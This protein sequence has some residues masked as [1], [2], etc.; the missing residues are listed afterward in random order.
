[1]RET[2][3]TAEHHAEIAVVIDLDA[4]DADTL[5]I[6]KHPDDARL[7]LARGQLVIVIRKIDIALG[8]APAPAALEAMV[9]SA[10]GTK[11]AW[12]GAVT[13][14]A[15]NVVRVDNS[16]ATDFAAGDRIVVKAYFD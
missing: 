12:D 9:F 3:L 10:V 11:R 15:G 8:D 6:E 2:D 16:G 4:I 5:A 14:Q 1:M 7:V 13:L